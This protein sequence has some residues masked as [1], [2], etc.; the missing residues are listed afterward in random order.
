MAEGPH[1]P[2]VI[3]MGHLVAESSPVLQGQFQHYRIFTRVFCTFMLIF[4]G[5]PA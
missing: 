2:G 3:D 5:S 4:M 1:P